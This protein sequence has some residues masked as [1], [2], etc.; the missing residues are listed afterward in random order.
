MLD[1]RTL[2]VSISKVCFITDLKRHVEQNH[3][4]KVE[5]QILIFAGRKMEE[6]RL[7]DY[8]VCNESTVQL[9]I[10]P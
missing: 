10:R 3:G 4:F 9:I 7:S 6:G 8:N 1:G 5:K 2:T